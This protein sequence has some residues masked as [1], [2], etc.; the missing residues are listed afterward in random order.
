MI[1]PDKDNNFETSL[2]FLSINIANKLGSFSDLTEIYIDFEKEF[3][4]RDIDTALIF[5]YVIGFEFK[6]GD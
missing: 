1:L 6:I 2:L 5:L 3:S 4:H